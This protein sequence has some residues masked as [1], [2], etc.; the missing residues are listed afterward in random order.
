MATPA[1]NLALDAA[2]LAVQA[3]NLI[4]L[5]VHDWIPLGRLNNLSAIRSQ[6]SLSYR[7][8]VTL[9]PAV[10]V[11]VPL[12]FTAMYFGDH[13]P[14]WLLMDL[15][16]TYG[17]L[18]VGLLRAWWVPYLLIP[19]QQRAARYQTIFAGTHTFLPIRNGIA[20]DTLHTLFHLNM[21][22]TIVLLLLR[23]NPPLAIS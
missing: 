4:F 18:F 22:A 15:W 21:L 8:F 14:H 19:D 10:P 1:S 17:I 23:S 3:V 5:L 7:L 20:P 9:L 12:Y 6:D 16:I 2:F 13:Y 11:A